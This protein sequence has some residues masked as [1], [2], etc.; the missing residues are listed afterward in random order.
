[1][2][3]RFETLLIGGHV[4]DGTGEEPRRA[5][6]GI[7]E[8]RVAE[9]GDYSDE[10]AARSIDVTGRLVLPGFIDVHSH[11]DSLIAT[12]RVTEAYLRQGVTTVIVGQDGLSFAPT[13]ARAAEYVD[14]YFAGIGG[15]VPEAL[16]EGT[17]VAGL[18]AHYDRLGPL[19]IALLVGAGSI[20]AQVV[21][22][23]ERAATAQEL[24]SMKALVSRGIDEGAL[25]VST[26]LDYVPGRFADTKELSSL[27]TAVGEAGGIHA[28]HLRGYAHD[29]LA[30]SLSELAQISASSGALGHVAHLHG[31]SSLVAN[32]LDECRERTG[33]G[34]TF[35]S[36]P[37]LRGS[38]IIAM[39][40]LPPHLQAGGADA[41][42]RRL[43]DP[44]V[45][46]ALRDDI[47]PLS[48]RLDSIVLSYLG[49]STLAWA[50]GLPLR[51]AANIAGRPLADFVCEI[52]IASDLAVG[53]VVDNG[54]D[55]T[56]KDAQALLRHPGHMAGSDAIF[57][58]N[59]PHPRGWGAFARLLGR[60]VRE[61][62]DWTWG[63][64]AHHLSGHAAE[65][66]GLVGRGR[67]SVG[68]VA[69]LVVV[70]PDTVSDTSTYDEPIRPAIGIDTVFVGGE[71][72]LADGHVSGRRSGRALR[73]RDASR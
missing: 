8:G 63:E 64:A 53:C 69:D 43:A 17:S 61:L 38:T 32:A 57:L 15:R 14:R 58:G 9:V 39:L 37:Y 49:D 68:A 56:E 34:L 40:L 71:I 4:V 26:G 11:A 46:R 21:G 54:A 10:S 3:T 59:R 30:A 19:N 6:V 18:L 5:D 25:G 35:D 23:D 27:M 67:V 48:T 1:M 52:L 62:G 60:H 31:P 66:F 12:E 13:D 41:T 20:R 45:R 33:V 24:H 36:Y 70:N 28:S 73:H 22:L 55:R 29:Q 2:N 7:A 16:L 44:V 42:L 50:E 65:R 47:L 51:D 72:A